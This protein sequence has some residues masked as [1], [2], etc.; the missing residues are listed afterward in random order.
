MKAASKHIVIVDNHDSFVYNLAAEI[1]PPGTRLS[2]F[3][4]SVDTG[5]IL[6]SQPDLICLSPGPGH[7]RTAGNLMEIIDQALGKIPLLGICLGF[8]ALLEYHG[9]DV[10]PVGAVHGQAHELT[11]TEDGQADPLFTAVGNA[12]RVA[13]YHSLG[14]TEVPGDLVSL[15]QIGQVCMA[16][17]TRDGSALGLQFHPESILTAAGPR[18]LANAVASLR[19]A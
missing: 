12:P 7:P 14:C 11:L 6:D 2:V 17:R 10:K 3:R 13:R 5:V 15:A 16:A 1:A 4:N 9:S 8:Q 19:I 18:I